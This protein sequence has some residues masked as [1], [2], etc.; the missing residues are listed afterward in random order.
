MDAPLHI[1]IDTREQ[2]PWSFPEDMA[3]CERRTVRT[4]DYA[5]ILEDGTVDPGFGE[6]R[7]TLADFVGTISTDWDRFVRE[8]G[9]MKEAAF[10][11]LIIIVEGYDSDIVAG[12]YNHPEITPAFVTSRIV[13]LQWMGVHVYMAGNPHRAAQFAWRHLYERWKQLNDPFWE[14][15][16]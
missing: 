4:G 12:D 11:V 6:E 15:C 10:P 5:L 9:R 16:K 2:T 1:A 13:R 3:T 7:K 14:V 8:I